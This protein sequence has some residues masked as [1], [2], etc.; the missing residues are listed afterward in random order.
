MYSLRSETYRTATF[1]KVCTTFVKNM[2]K[3]ATDASYKTI[4]PLDVNYTT[5]MIDYL[6][7]AIQTQDDNTE[8]QDKALDSIIITVK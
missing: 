3:Y 7:F 6:D 1:D 8:L 2:F 4:K 5:L